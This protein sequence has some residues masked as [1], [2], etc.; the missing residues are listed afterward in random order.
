MTMI[1]NDLHI[2][3]VRK[4]G[5]TPAS[6]EALRLF[7]FGRFA[8]L[9]SLSKDEDVLIAGDLFDSFEIAPR[10]WVETYNI[11]S[12]WCSSHT[13]S[14]WIVAGNHDH[15][16]RGNKMSSF[17]VLAHV[18]S[19]QF[20]NVFVVGIDEWCMVSMGV[21]ALA[22]CS[23]QDIFDMRL[24]ECL[25]DLGLGSTLILHANYANNF[26]DAGDHS[27]NVKN[28]VARDFI[29]KGINLVFAHEH[30]SRVEFPVGSR[31][32]DASLT[33]LG[34]QIPSS[35]ADCLGNDSKFYW[36]IDEDGLNKHQFWSRQDEHGYV[37]IN[38]RDLAL[39]CDA[40][41]IRVNGDATSNEASEVIDAIHKFR[42]RT[43]AFVVGNSVKIDGIAEIDSLPET[44]EAA[45]KFDV[46]DFI[47]KQLDEAE[48]DV[49]REIVEELQ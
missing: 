38:W 14:L 11:L 27:L 29:N 23:N 2:G 16:A 4:G 10:D 24:G 42:V 7:M 9:M 13:E 46:L 36:R 25:D 26:A 39:G 22:H 28:D 20:N 19:E 31:E 21:Y 40:A 6:Q 15:S 1:I 49:I 12:N 30:Q 35:I 32:G 5:T 17:Q 45:K 3:A 41:F 34:N 48:A 47:Y 37:E 43:N 44:F 8:E 18:M 33:V